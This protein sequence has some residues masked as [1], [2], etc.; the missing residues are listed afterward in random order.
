MRSAV[1]RKIPF[2]HEYTKQ[3][4]R[5][6]AAT[7]LAA[8]IALTVGLFSAHAGWAARVSLGW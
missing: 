6:V 5:V 7:A 1:N 3:V 2:M 4:G 8:S